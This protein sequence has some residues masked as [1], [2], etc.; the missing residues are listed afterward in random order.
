MGILGS[1]DFFFFFL[2]RKCGGPRLIKKGWGLNKWSCGCSGMRARRGVRVQLSD[3][4]STCCMYNVV[5]GSSSAP[6][7][8]SAKTK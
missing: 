6:E 2:E 4:P 7:R 8:V 3:S 5:S 1:G